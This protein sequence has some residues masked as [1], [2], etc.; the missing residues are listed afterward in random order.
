MPVLAVILQLLR[1]VFPYKFISTNLSCADSDK[2]ASV[3]SL[4]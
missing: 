3:V 4:L 1:L 2:G